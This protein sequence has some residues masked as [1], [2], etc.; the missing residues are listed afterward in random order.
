MNENIIKREL[1][2]I[3]FYVIQCPVEY[4]VKQNTKKISKKGKYFGKL[5]YSPQDTIR[6]LSEIKKLINNNIIWCNNEI[7]VK[8][9]EKNFKKSKGYSD[10]KF[11]YIAITE[12]ANMRKTKTIFYMIRNAFAHGDYEYNEKQITFKCEK[13]NVLK[14][15]MRLNVETLFKIKELYLTKSFLKEDSKNGN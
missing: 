8:N 2:L 15:L 9:A 14:C 10:K 1:N 4:K 5:N 6:L 11:E 12:N 7:E 3:Y 13:N